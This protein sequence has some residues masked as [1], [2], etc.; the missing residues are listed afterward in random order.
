MTRYVVNR[1]YQ[2]L[3]LLLMGS[4]LVFLMIHIL[5]GGP[6][7]A[8]IGPDA[9]V[10]AIEAMNKKMGFDKPLY[11][12]YL[13]WIGNVLRGDMGVS[14]LSNMAVTKLLWLKFLATLQLVIG[15]FT[16]AM[17]TSFPLGILGAIKHRSLLDRIAVTY[18][19]IGIA[20]PTFWLGI[21]LV[22]L[23]GLH[24][25][26]LPTSGYESFWTSPGKAIRFLILPAVTLGTYIGAVQVRFIRSSLLEVLDQDYIRT[27]RSKGL[28]ERGVI[29]THALK[30]AF[31]SVITVLGMQ[32]GTFLT[33]SVV[34]EA[35]FK[36]PGMGQMLL[37]SITQRDYALVQ[38]TILFFL[39]LFVV[40]NLVVDMSYAW[41]DPRIR[42]T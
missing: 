11:L 14:Y 27:A 41:L 2:T 8:L 29:G 21:L 31:I 24:L 37:Q 13:I 17:L 15:A 4:I 40:V 9:P 1:F 26:W 34:T 42:F 10:E 22:L 35:L 12:Q 25:G 3:L 5:P 28:P 23:F 38:G 39:A 19:S 33:G 6:V 30:N 18:G 32:L 36:W 7:I 20:I 16:V